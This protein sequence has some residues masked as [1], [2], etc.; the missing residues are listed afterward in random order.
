M[1]FLANAP[2]IPPGAKGNVEID[3]IHTVSN[4][5]LI[6]PDTDAVDFVVSKTSGCDINLPTTIQP[7]GANDVPF[8]VN[9]RFGAP[10]LTASNTGATR[11][12]HLYVEATNTG[13]GVHV[14]YPILSTS[15]AVVRMTS[16]EAANEGYGGQFKCKRVYGSNNTPHA[17][18][19]LGTIDAGGYIPVIQSDNINMGINANL[20]VNV[21][22]SGNGVLVRYP[23]ATNSEGDLKMVSTDGYGAS[24]KCIR[25]F[26][27]DGQAPIGT[28][29]L[30]TI[31]NST[32]YTPVLQADHSNM[33]IN[34]NL[35]INPP[36]NVDGSITVKYRTIENSEAS[37]KMTSTDNYGGA[38]KCIRKTEVAGVPGPPEGRFELGTIDAGNYTTVLTSNNANMTIPVN[39]RIKGNTG[40]EIAFGKLGQYDVMWSSGNGAASLSGRPGNSGQTTPAQWVTIYL[41]GNQ[42]VFPVWSFN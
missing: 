42:Y 28:I 36:L 25:K 10:I 11:C 16:S 5:E 13:N 22:A 35:T 20:S 14:K 27:A 34:G 17:Q 2:Y 6:D 18:I 15:E 31:D 37:Y 33:S 39:L 23:T 29:E 21:P 38:F 1:V 26:V 9:D 8:L 4:F 7:S 24:V 30:G 32:A 3:G 40:N 19:E 12:Q 41:N